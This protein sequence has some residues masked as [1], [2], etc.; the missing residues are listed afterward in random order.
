MVSIADFVG[1]GVRPPYS[2]IGSECPRVEGNDEYT[3]LICSLC[4]LIDCFDQE[5]TAQEPNKEM[6]DKYVPAWMLNKSRSPGFVEVAQIHLCDEIDLH[7]FIL[8]QM[9]LIDLSHHMDREM[10]CW[11][12]GTAELAVAGSPQDQSQQE[13]WAIYNE[14]LQWRRWG[15]GWV[16]LAG[17][18]CFSLLHEDPAR[19]QRIKSNPPSP[20]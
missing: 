3:S 20:V 14:H 12:R 2:H 10:A 8:F 1:L 15:Q 4:F 13:F 5:G 19:G 6:V 7:R 11:G 18:Q 9:H 16:M 17:G